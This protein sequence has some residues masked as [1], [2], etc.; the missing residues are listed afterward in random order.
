MRTLIR[1]IFPLAMLILSTVAIQAQP[2]VVSNTETNR[3]A[4]PYR[5]LTSGKQITIKSTKDIRNV[6]VWSSTGNRIV[7]QKDINADS[8]NFRLSAN[9]KLLFIRIQLVD[10]KVYSE[11]VGVR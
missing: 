6:M 10:G 7:E 3:P 4:K 8:Y 1:S 9:E 5:I 2:V 11:R